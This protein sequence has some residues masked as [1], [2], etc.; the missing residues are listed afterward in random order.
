MMHNMDAC[1]RVL[2]EIEAEQDQPEAKPDD[3]TTRA[4]CLLVLRSIPGVV[5]GTEIFPGPVSPN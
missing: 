3:V 1:G 2:S 4:R 5:L